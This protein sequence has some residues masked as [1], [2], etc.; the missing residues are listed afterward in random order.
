[1]GDGKQEQADT[2]RVRRLEA[3]VEEL[4]KRLEALEQTVGEIDLEIREFMESE[5]VGATQ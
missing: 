3:T 2:Q 5:D 4:R 1:M